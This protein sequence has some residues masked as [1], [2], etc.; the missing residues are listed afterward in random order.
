MQWWQ[1]L[2]LGCVQGLTEFLPVSSSGHLQITEHL[3]GLKMV[4]LAF[5]IWLHLGTL[6]AVLIYFREQIRSMTWQMLS[7]IG[8]ASLPIFIGGFV[9]MDYI[10][11]LRTDLSALIIT[12]AISAVVLFLADSIL[13]SNKGESIKFKLMEKI[14]QRLTN[15]YPP[16]LTQALLI[17][18]FQVIAI[19]PGVSRSGITVSAGIF[20]GLPRDQ[21]FSF[22]FLIS[23]PAIIGAIVL[24]VIQLLTGDSAVGI[25]VLP[26]SVYLLGVTASAIVGWLALSILRWFIDQRIL[27]PFAIYSALVS[28]LLVLFV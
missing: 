7:K 20:T 19:L 8:L 11:Q 10:I 17:G 4:P 13:R 12:Y 18:L 23:L 21:V 14:H 3:F 6:L 27:W 1:A 25:A 15:K 26:W 22:A 5:D 9:F 28:I 16:S 2:I 24:N